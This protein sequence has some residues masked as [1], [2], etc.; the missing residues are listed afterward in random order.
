MN[1][2]NIEGNLYCPNTDTL[3]EAPT[4]YGSARWHESYHRDRNE[5][6]TRNATLTRP[7]YRLA[8]KDEHGTT[9]VS[10]RRPRDIVHCPL[11]HKP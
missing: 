4:Q 8:I 7:S 2:P 5:M 6:E 1:Q 9:S 11:K 10:S 3:A